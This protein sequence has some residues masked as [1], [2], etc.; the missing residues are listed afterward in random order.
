MMTYEVLAC[1]LVAERPWHDMI[2]TTKTH[3][4]V[5]DSRDAAQKWM[6]SRLSWKT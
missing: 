3:Q 6:V 5:W 1:L 4:D 2:E